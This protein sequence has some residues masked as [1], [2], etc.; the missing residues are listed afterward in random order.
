MYFRIIQ[1]L[2]FELTFLKNFIIQLYDL[3]INI[4]IEI[5]ELLISTN[6]LRIFAT[7]VLILTLKIT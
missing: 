3:L 6:I 7:D 1:A 2:V 4:N 5:S